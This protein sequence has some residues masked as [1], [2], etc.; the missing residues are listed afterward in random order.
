MVGA[1]VLIR[2][3]IDSKTASSEP[4]QRPENATLFL[5]LVF[6]GGILVSAIGMTCHLLARRIIL[7][8]RGRLLGFL[9][10]VRS[11]RHRTG[12]PGAWTL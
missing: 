9:F 11:L 2:L 6:A 5:P 3:R 4:M 1:F 8:D 10:A 7:C 12:V